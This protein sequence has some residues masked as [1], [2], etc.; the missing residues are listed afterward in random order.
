MALETADAQNDPEEAEFAG[1]R[2]DPNGDVGGTPH[3]LA[4][5]L[6]DVEERLAKE[7]RSDYLCTRRMAVLCEMQWSARNRTCGS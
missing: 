7:P 1:M 4:E 2:R 3:M 6:A 5:Q